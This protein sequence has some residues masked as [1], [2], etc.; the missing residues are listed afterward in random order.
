MDCWLDLRGNECGRCSEE[1]LYVHRMRACR[2]RGPGPRVQAAE[3]DAPRRR[4]ERAH[5]ARDL[6]PTQQGAPPSHTHTRTHTHSHI[7]IETHSC[8]YYKLLCIIF[9]VL[10]ALPPPRYLCYDLW[11]IIILILRVKAG[12]YCFRACRRNQPHVLMWELR[13]ASHGMWTR[14]RRSVRRSTA[15]R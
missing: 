10:Q 14:R 11:V 6:R 7:R 8:E 13:A 3:L 12:S 1:V 9:S 5:I 2:A 15:R 4:P